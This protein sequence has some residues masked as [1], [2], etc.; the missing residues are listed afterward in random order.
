MLNRINYFLMAAVLMPFAVLA[1]VVE[2][3]PVEDVLKSL[4]DLVG[5]IKGGSALVI[6]A[7]VIQL[8]MK[9]AGSKIGSYAG[10][11]KLLIVGVLSL[12]SQIVAVLS[13]GGSIVGALINGSVLAAV[14]VLVHQVYVQFIKKEGEE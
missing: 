4:L 6:S 13:S 2:E 11:W 10:K 12:G 1:Q 3:V 8:L 7:L 5:G 14:Q 9:V